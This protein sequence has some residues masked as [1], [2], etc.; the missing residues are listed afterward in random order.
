MNELQYSEVLNLLAKKDVIK[1][2]FLQPMRKDKTT[3][4]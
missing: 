4:N 2:F 1:F 3:E